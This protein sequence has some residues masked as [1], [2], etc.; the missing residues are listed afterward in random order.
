MNDLELEREIRAAFRRR[1]LDIGDP[2]AL[3][4]SRE[5]VGRARRRQLGT[6]VTTLALV[7][8]VVV[9]SFV[10]VSALVRSS[11]REVPAGPTGGAVFVCPPES[12][13]DRPGPVDQ[14]RPAEQL[15]DFAGITFDR[16]LGRIILSAEGGL[17]TFDVCTNT[18]RRMAPAAEQASLAYDVDSHMTVSLG[19][20]V[21][22]YDPDRDTRIRMGDPPVGTWGPQ[23]VYDPV[24]GLLF[25]FVFDPGRSEIRP[26]R[27]EMWTYD[28]DT[29]T[30]RQIDQRGVVP[31]SPASAPAAPL[32]AY[33]AS[34]DRIV[35][36]FGDEC[37]EGIIAQPCAGDRTFEFDPRSHTW[38]EAHTDS[39]DL[40]LGAWVAPRNLITYDEANERTVIFVRGTVAT[41]DATADEWEI[42][43][44]ARR[45]DRSLLDRNHAPIVYDP[46]NERI[47]VIGGEGGGEHGIDVWAF[48]LSTRE[49]IQL[50]ASTPGL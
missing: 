32:L 12:T 44:D 21:W 38:S 4:P 1:E 37:G 19:A 39:P 41:Y 29:D 8:A 13:P 14:D 9:G 2:A 42:V 6:V 45:A 22:A 24:S 30:W 31:L 28:V 50:L 26:E 20:S 40:Q 11:G 17:W 34:A 10:G 5:A 3:P 18:W 33:D 27:S 25:I 48:D 46:V 15:L 47:V 49:W 23:P 36:F 43:F 7:A 16:G 35:L